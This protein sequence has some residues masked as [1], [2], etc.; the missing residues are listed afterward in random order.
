[1]LEEDCDMEGRGPR[2]MEEVRE[3]LTLEFFLFRRRRG[4]IART[5]D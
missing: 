4:R 3:L 1:M 5:F 2:H